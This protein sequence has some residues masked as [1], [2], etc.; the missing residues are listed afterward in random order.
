MPHHSRKGPLPIE[1]LI[2]RRLAEHGI[3]PLDLVRKCG[4]ANLAKG[5]RRLEEV[6]TGNLARAAH[7]IEALPTSLDLPADQVREAVQKSLELIRADEQAAWRAAFRPHAVIATEHSVPRP[8][9]AG[10]AMGI[11]RQ[12]QIDFDASLP[13]A[14][15]HAF[16]QEEIVRRLAMWNGVIATFGKAMGYTINWRADLAERFDLQGNLV[17][18]LPHAYLLHNGSITVKAKDITPILRGDEKRC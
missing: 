2:S 17:E 10:V 1:L 16:V 12:K 13:T 14:A 3:R 8:I 18:T 5:L 7:L 15:I 4:Y 9:F 6:Y 11:K